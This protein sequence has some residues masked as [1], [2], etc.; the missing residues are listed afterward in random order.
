[1]GTVKP[2]GYRPATDEDLELDTKARTL[3][4]ESLKNIRLAAADWAK[5]ITAITG[6]LGAVT[7]VKGPE[8]ISDLV[9][10]AKVLVGLFVAAGLVFALSA[11]VSAA[12]ASEG[13]PERGW[14]IGKELLRRYSDER[15]RATAQLLRSRHHAV[16]AAACLIVAVGI[17]WYSPTETAAPKPAKVLVVF[18][19]RAPICGELSNDSSGLAATV[20]GENVSIH[21]GNVRSLNVVSACPKE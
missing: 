6:I 15:D 12:Y 1:M 21:S 20:K 3:L 16:A 9:L 17:A 19:D 13:T 4:D 14:A 10:V 8:D 18:S 7:L 11:I 2:V 5:T